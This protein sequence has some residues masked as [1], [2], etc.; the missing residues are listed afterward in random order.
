MKNFLSYHIKNI[1]TEYSFDRSA[2]DTYLYM[3]FKANRALGS[4]DRKTVQHCVY[5]YYKYLSAFTAIETEDLPSALEEYSPQTSI[6]SAESACLPPDL[7]ERLKKSTGNSFSD[8]VETITTQAPFTVRVNTLLSDRESVLSSLMEKGFDVAKTESSPV[9]ITFKTR[10]Q[11]RQ[12]DEFTKGYIEIQDESSQIASHITNIRPGYK[13]L[14][15]CCGSGGKAL[16]LGAQLEGK[17]QL[18]IHDIRSHAIAQA[19]LR[20]KRASIQNYQKLSLDNCDHLLKSMDV[21]FIDA[22][23]SGT[24]TFRRHPEQKWRCDNQMIDELIDIQKSI[25][26]EALPF[27]KPKGHIVYATCSVLQEENQLQVEDF[28]KTYNLKLVVPYFSTLPKIDGG[29][30][31]FAAVLTSN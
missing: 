28:M 30:G 17:G 19:K 7:F 18:Y 23:C 20:L 9:G 12:L 13:V 8:Y 11:I 2:L 16:S 27:V 26:H 5:T 21:V 24:G 31:F 4:H 6:E 10:A 22:P 15:Y 25:F 29:D 3:Y 1:I 14:D